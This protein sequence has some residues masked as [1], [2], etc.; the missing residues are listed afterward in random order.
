MIQARV[1]SRVEHS[2]P[3]LSAS[4]CILLVQVGILSPGGYVHHLPS[5]RAGARAGDE[6]YYE[7]ITRV[8]LSHDDVTAAYHCDS[9]VETGQTGEDMERK[10]SPLLFSF[11]PP[12][13]SPI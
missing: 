11:Q 1:L 7:E 9:T 2:C 3:P 5:K 6:L 8:R 10:H 12:H 4:T 13:I